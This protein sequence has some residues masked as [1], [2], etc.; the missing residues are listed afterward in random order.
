MTDFKKLIAESIDSDA[1]KYS[2]DCGTPQE[3]TRE[4]AIKYGE[5][6]ELLMVEVDKYC[7]LSHAP[8]LEEAIEKITKELKG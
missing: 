6:L 4:L 7:D 1:D 3:I 5:M 8:K 2:Y